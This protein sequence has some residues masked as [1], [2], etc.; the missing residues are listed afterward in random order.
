MLRVNPTKLIVEDVIETEKVTTSGIVLP[1]AVIKTKQM[2][3]IILLKGD[4]TNDI[5]MV[6]EVGDTCIYHPNAGSKFTWQGK[7]VRT[8][9]VGEVLLSGV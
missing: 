4:G 7:E 6:H 5:P 8:I 2:R 3:G 1:S 9:D